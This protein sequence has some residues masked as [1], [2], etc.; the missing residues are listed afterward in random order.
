[1]NNPDRNKRDPDEGDDGFQTL[2][3]IGPQPQQVIILDNVSELMGPDLKKKKIQLELYLKEIIHEGEIEKLKSKHEVEIERLK[4]KQ[5]RE[6]KDILVRGGAM[7]EPVHAAMVKCVAHIASFLMNEDWR[8][9]MFSS[10]KLYEASKVL[11]P[12]WTDYGPVRVD[13]LTDVVV[14]D[15][16]PQGSHNTQFDLGGG[17]NFKQRYKFAMRDWSSIYIIDGQFV[18]TLEHRRTDFMRGRCPMGLGNTI[19]FSSKYIVTGG[20]DQRIK[21]WLNH[22]SYELYD[23]TLQFSGIIHDVAITFDSMF[24][25]IRTSKTMKTSKTHNPDYDRGEEISIIKI[26]DGGQ[27]IN[28]ITFGTLRFHGSM[29]FSETTDEIVFT[30]S[31]NVSPETLG[32]IELIFWK[33]VHL[34]TALDVNKRRLSSNVV[35]GGETEIGLSSKLLVG[36]TQSCEVK[37]FQSKDFFGF[38]QIGEDNPTVGPI[39]SKQLLLEILA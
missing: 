21:L 24:L 13:H 22:G 4:S 31:R 1:M 28:T 30:G 3:F 36:G 9:L 5:Q 16:H 26:G 25:A 14:F 23:D 20:A 2:T 32:T 11:D 10:K 8:R 39:A 29:V 12:A 38:S 18:R 19:C 7:N 37:D 15:P 17:A 34:D 33:T 6:N 35:I 27:V